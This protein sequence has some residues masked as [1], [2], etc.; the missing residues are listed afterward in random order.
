MLKGQADKKSRNFIHE[1]T[2][3]CSVA[4]TRQVEVTH[5]QVMWLMFVE[6]HADSEDEAAPAPDNGKD[7][8]VAEPGLGQ[9]DHLDELV[10]LSLVRMF[11]VAEHLPDG[12][13]QVLLD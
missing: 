1:L 12:R 2:F 5:E 8:E 11:T 7:V 9:L 13:W 4:A 10:R 3:W 6:V